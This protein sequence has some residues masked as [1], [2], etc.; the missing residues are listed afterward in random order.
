VEQFTP[1]KFLVLVVDDI[2]RN[3]Q[4][5]VD[6]LDDLGYA[7]TFA[8]SGK[9]ALERVET[10]KPDLILLDLMMPEIDGIEVCKILKS[11]PEY[12][13]IPVI[14]L[15]AS[16]ETEHL[17]QAFEA[18]AVD[19]ITKPFN[20]PELVARV[21]T[22][23]E[24]KQTR[25]NLGKTLIEL[26]QS[27]EEA[28]EAARIKSQFLAN[29]SHEIRT[30][31]NAVL[32]MTELLLK[33][34]I[35]EQ[36]LDFLQ[37]LKSSGEDLLMIINDILDFS[38]L[39][40]GEMRLEKKEFGLKNVIEQIFNLLGPQV[41]N[42][43]IQL[44]YEISSDTPTFLIG[45]A[46]RL[47][48]ILLN[49]LGNGIKFTDQGK[50][51]LKIS[52]KNIRHENESLATLHFMIQDTGIGIDSQN[53]KKL[54]QSFSQIDNS[55]TR[56]YGGTGLGLAICKQLVQLMEGQIGVDSV[57]NQGSSFWFTATFKLSTNEMIE[58]E[59]LARLP[60]ANIEEK[61]PD[62]HY[63]KL[64]IVEDTLINQKV[65]LN[66][67]QL[68]GYQADCVRNG[69]EALEILADLD[70]DLIFMD[71]QMPILDG[72]KTTETLREWEAKDSNSQP[73][74]RTIIGL[75]AY[76]MQ[77]DREKCLASG[78]D[79]YLSK[80]VSIENLALILNKWLNNSR[81]KS[82]NLTLQDLANNSS[83]SSSNTTTL[84]LDL[85]DVQRFYEVIGGD[86]EF[87]E[88]IMTMFLE[89]VEIYLREMKTYFQD[90]DSKNLASKAH[91]IKGSASNLGLI[92]LAELAHQLEKKGSAENLDGVEL[93]LKQLD[94]VFRQVKESELPIP[95]L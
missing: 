79:D 75:T 66:Q 22:H 10:A 80:P 62:F 45:D 57:I 18:G 46:S 20:A 17:L 21:H 2:S 19:Y 43:K 6:I 86:R 65:L 70:Y 91:Q 64:L 83:I 37:T 34:P 74:H 1:E 94:Q 88:S 26:K 58:E 73:Y 49:L 29:M 84:E 89:D 3:I 47:R 85:W 92:K 95:E 68:L 54:F 77:G 52:L 16:H 13:D 4:V 40:A 25:D 38:K 33:T 5:V 41:A 71:C 31:M 51:Y 7:T 35:N 14:F 28:L 72:Y 76:A 9:Q 67:L 48:Q 53:Q 55:S 60:I 12:L 32:G 69:Q 61:A 30:P 87:G 39:E 93:I 24:L 27:R 15:T 63:D 78:M 44:S 36:Q 82:L 11:N 56:Q 23:L 81:Q 50:V 42:K 90:Q 59:V 8:T